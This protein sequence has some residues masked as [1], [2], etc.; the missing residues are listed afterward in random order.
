MRAARRTSTATST[1][2]TSAKGAAGSTRWIIARESPT[3]TMPRASNSARTGRAPTSASN[4]VARWTRQRDPE[5]DRAA[6]PAVVNAP[7]VPAPG[8]P[9]LAAA[10][11]RRGRA[12]SLAG[13]AVAAAGWA[14]SIEASRSIAKPSAGTPSNR[15]RPSPEPEA[16]VVAA[17]PAEVVAVAVDPVVVG[18]AAA[19]P[20]EVVAVAAE[21][22]VA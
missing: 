15:E 16:V 1:A 20:A 7:A 21:L 14:A 22:A 19:D 9:G 4:F 3:A 6:V 17:D 13:L 12:P 11:A 18:A 8:E 2:T 5:A 10:A